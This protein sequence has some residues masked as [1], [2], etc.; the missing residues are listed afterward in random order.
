[1]VDGATVILF[2]WKY[3]LKITLLKEIS[4]Q[5]LFDLSFDKW[6]KLNCL[7]KSRISECRSSYV[8]YFLFPL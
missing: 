8:D 7:E 4:A 5:Q 2:A 6:F 3:W 1:M